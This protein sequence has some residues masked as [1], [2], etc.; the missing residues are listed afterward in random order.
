MKRKRK[1][2]PYLEL[3]SNEHPSG[4]SLVKI[5]VFS[6]RRLKITAMHGRKSDHSG[7]QG[8]NELF[9]ER[10]AINLMRAILD[11]PQCAYAAVLHYPPEIRRDCLKWRNPNL[12]PLSPEE[13]AAHIQRLWLNARRW[14]AKNRPSERLEYIWVMEWQ[15]KP[16]PH[17][18]VLLSHE[19]PTSVLRDCWRRAILA[20]RTEIRVS[21][22][23]PWVGYSRR[24]YSNEESKAFYLAKW[25]EGE[26]NPPLGSGFTADRI[27]DASR[28]GGK[29]T[30]VS[31][32]E[33]LRDV[34]RDINK[35]Q[36]A[37]ERNKGMPKKSLQVSDRHGRTVYTAS[38]NRVLLRHA[39]RLGHGTAFAV[40]R[41]VASIHAEK[42]SV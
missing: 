28:L 11:R 29:R 13:V 42:V 36:R 10:Q 37:T 12:F 3:P 39:T 8:R 1:F 7:Y 20:T 40:V 35:I 5:E 38:S 6:E 25:K 24:K 4:E 26:K 27:W 31:S 23:T 9:S 21:S 33:R 17:F 2:K 18:H 15:E 32:R 14:M 16:Y 19:I 41:V 22:R 30:Y 34:L